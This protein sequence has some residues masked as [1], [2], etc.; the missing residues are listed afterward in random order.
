MEGLV[1]AKRAEASDR[2]PLYT[3]DQKLARQSKVAQLVP[4][5]N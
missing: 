2:A 1:L 4:A 5:A 3:F